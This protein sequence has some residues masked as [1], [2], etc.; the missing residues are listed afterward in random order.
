[1]KYSFACLLILGLVLSS[2]K[3]TD[4]PSNQSAPAVDV[5]G[6]E[7]ISS[8]IYTLYVK[9]NKKSIDNKV[10]IVVLKNDDGSLAYGPDSVKGDVSWHDE[11][12]L[13][14]REFPEVIEDK[15]GTS[16]YLYYIHIP[17]TKKNYKPVEKM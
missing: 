3:S 10:T 16:E 15:R 5:S 7:A 8:T 2:C 17:T 12:Q 1:M 9:A 13:I 4:K 14:V 6:Y 11:D